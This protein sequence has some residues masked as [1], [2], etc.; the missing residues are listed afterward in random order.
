MPK[1]NGLAVATTTQVL[2]A[3]SVK[4]VEVLTTERRGE[5]A[6]QRLAPASLGA[7]RRSQGMNPTLGADD[8]RDAALVPGTGPGLAAGLSW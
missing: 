8:A 1:R 3:R 2:Q 5:Q 6:A 4:R 7:H